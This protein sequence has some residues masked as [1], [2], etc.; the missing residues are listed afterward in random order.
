MTIQTT[1]SKEYSTNCAKLYLAF[2]LGKQK[3]KLGFTIGLG[4][5]PRVRTIDGGDLEA[6]RWEIRQAKKR[7]GLAQ[8]VLVMSCYEAGRDGFW[9]HRYLVSEEIE[10]LVVDS[11]SI[12]VKRRA[13]RVKTDRL[14]VQKLVSMLIRYDSGEKKVWSVVHVPSIEAEDKRHLHRQLSALKADRTRHTNRIKGLLAGQGVHMAV[15]GDFLEELEAVRLWDG[16]PLSPGLRSRLERE[17]ACWQFLNQQIQEREAERTKMIRASDDAS[18]EKVR[19]LLRLRG[20]GDN[21]AWL[22]VMEFFGWREFRNR[23]E[24]GALAGLTSTPYLSGE[25]AQ[26]QGISKAGNRPVR[27]IAIEIAWGWLR[28]QPESELSLWYQDRFAHGGKRLRKIGIVALARKLLIALW[29]YLETGAIPAG[30]QLKA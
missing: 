24:V 29:R 1:H 15:K 27:G 19:H 25:E 21:S 28:H 14:D 30:A 9:L 12:E 23:R 5:R 18:V 22:F 2:E 7:F 8:T 20:I 4:Q 10:N 17:Y 16:A 13:R 11:S 3:W 6:L 26:E